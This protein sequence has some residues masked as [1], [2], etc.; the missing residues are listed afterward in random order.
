MA[1]GG[2][3]VVAG[4]IIAPLPGPFG[5]PIALVGLA[6]ILRNSF[7]A[8][9]LF[10]RAQYA[11]PRV[12][13]PFRRLLRKRPEFAP[14]MWQQM[15]RVEKLALRRGRGVLVRMRKRLRRELRD[16]IPVPGL[17]PRTAM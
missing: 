7:W 14:V 4:I 15:L 1:L 3:I 13:Y 12:V 16:I 2:L 9:R 17:Y 5:L 11:R 10:I 8:K 6:M